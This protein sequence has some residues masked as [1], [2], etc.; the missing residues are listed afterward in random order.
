MC[1]IAGLL[2][3]GGGD[4]GALGA[5]ARAMADAIRHRGPD[6]D[7]LWLDAEAG[8]ALAHRRLAII[9]LS[10]QG[11]QPMHSADGRY[12]LV[13][14]G[15]VYNFLELRRELEALGHAFRGHSDSEVM[16]AAICQ[17][18]LKPALARFV[19]MFAFA[20]WD[21]RTRVLHLVRDRL[22]VKP[23]LWCRRGGLLLFGSEL[24]ALEA[25]AACPRELDRDALALYFRRNCIPAPFSVYRGVH[26]LPPASILSFAAG[27]R[28]PRIESYWSLAGV[29][30]AGQARPFAGDE[31]EAAAELDRQLMEAVRCRLVADV[32]LGVFLSGGIDSS[33]VTALMQQAS[34]APVKSF[35]IGFGQAGY[36]E[37]SD[38]AAVARHLGT[39]HQELYVS[40]AEALRLVPELGRLLDEPFGDSSFLPT[41]LVAR[42]ARRQVTVALSGD[43]GDELFGGYNRHLWVARVARL[44]RLPR[45]LRRVLACGLQALPPAAWDRLA[46]LLRQRNPGDKLHKLAGILAADGES[47]IYQGL[48]SHWREPTRLLPGAREPADLPRRPADWPRLPHFTQTMMYLDAMTY[49]PDDILH[50]VDRASMA[51]SLEAREPLLDHRLVEFAWRLPLSMQISGGVG[52]RLLRQVLYKH[53]PRALVKRPKMG[54]A[55]P[56]ADWLRGPLRDWAEDL[57]QPA[58]LADDGLL[59]PAPIRR[60]WAEHLSGRRNW[61]HLLWDVLALQAWRQARRA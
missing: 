37:A 9:D 12:V 4:A 43:G 35:S 50:K 58:R 19:G 17:W 41:H 6:S 53:V 25:H 42:L 21:R 51:A 23:L 14:N 40:E 31:A 5:A 27:D 44:A 3:T 30:E 45:S 33:T 57:L 28:E 34:S 48:T 49:L 47:A 7:G 54:F 10:A 52:K 36:N 59:E 8:V 11:H 29:A 60:L 55:V 61:Q 2:A 39:Q 15:E 24:K 32:P 26:K 38:A 20:L 1:G 13:Y 18:G 56:L 22:G 16:L 46:G